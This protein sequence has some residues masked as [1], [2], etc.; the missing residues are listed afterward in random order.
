MKNRNELL[1]HPVYSPFC[2][3]S[4]V[5]GG[6]FHSGKIAFNTYACIQFK[7][8]TGEMSAVLCASFWLR[9]NFSH[10]EICIYYSNLIAQVRYVKILT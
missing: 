10:V 8:K 3:P 9:R 6:L 1:K 4:F 7:F 2:K 5:K